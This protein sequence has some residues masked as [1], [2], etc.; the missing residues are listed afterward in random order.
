MP[1]NGHGAAAKDH[2][3]T[4]D[5]V[6]IPQ[7]RRVERQIQ[8]LLAPIGQRLVTPLAQASAAADPR[9]APRALDLAG[10]VA[11]QQAIEAVYWQHRE[12]PAANPQP[13]PALVAV[14]PVEA[15]RAKVLDSTA[16][17]S[18][19]DT[20][21][22]RPITGEQLQAEINRMVQNSK[23]PD[24]LRALFSALGND[25]GLVA[26][27]LARPLLA[28]RLIREAY[29]SGLQ[30]QGE[31]QQPFD[32]WW[33]NQRA[34]H[35]ADLAPLSFSYTLPAA[36]DQVLFMDFWRSTQSLP[37]QSNGSAVWTG[38]EMIVWG[39]GGLGGGGKWRTGSRYAPATDSWTTMTTIDAP[40]RRSIHTA[41][42]TGEE[43]IVWGGCGPFEL[44]FCDMQNG[45]RY[46]PF[47]DTWTPTSLVGAPS[48]RLYHTAV[49]TGSEMIIWG[50]QT[51]VDQTNTGGRYDPVSDLGRKLHGDFQGEMGNRYNQRW[52]G[53]RIKHQMGPVSIKLYDK[54]N[55]VLRIETTVNDAK[56]PIAGLSVNA[57]AA[58]GFPRIKKADVLR[59]GQVR[60]FA[61]SGSIAGVI[62]RTDLQCG[63]WKAPA[64]LET[65]ISGVIGLTVKL[66]D[67]E[68]GELNPLGV[69]CLRT[70]PAAGTVI[71]GARTMV[72]DD[73]LASQLS[74]PAIHWINCSSSR[75]RPGPRC[76]IL[77]VLPSYFRPNLLDRTGTQAVIP[78]LVSTSYHDQNYQTHFLERQWCARRVQEWLHGLAGRS[79]C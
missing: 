12:W 2:R 7:Q 23:R 6:L 39:G 16:K 72:G 67:P 8:P 26:E 63:V 59:N 30:L 27:C 65:T 37:D 15:I 31:A 13:K 29:A 1:N 77:C 60:E 4:H 75:L 61:P 53:R 73:R 36:P 57:N 79:R 56:Q 70:M 17:S 47:M 33:A 58:L 40:L 62:A 25:P 35:R 14:M 42:W 38:T 51:E 19:L 48:S 11:C 49:W 44:R 55:Q 74:A 76:A 52:L 46:N 43:M 78:S 21:W 45:G 32:D 3:D 10:R 34:Q 68:N 66:T 64:G 71:C 69:N 28:D 5:A 50:G 41:V 24:L 9:A 54:F 20:L 22:Q 18:A